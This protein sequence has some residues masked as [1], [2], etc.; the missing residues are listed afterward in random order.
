MRRK[1]DL[2]GRCRKLAIQT[3]RE[4]RKLI[5][6]PLTAEDARQLIKSTGSIGANYIEANEALSK[7]D[8]VFR[9]KISLKECK[10]SQYWLSLLIGYINLTEAKE[11]ILLREEV[12]QIRKILGTILKKSI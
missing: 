9:I 1:Y 7:K 11:L 4:T 6:T 5:T 2:E 12:V 8:F 10:E 3:R